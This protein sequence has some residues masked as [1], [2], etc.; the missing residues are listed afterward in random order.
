MMKILKSTMECLGPS[1]ILSKDYTNL[2]LSISQLNSDS[3]VLRKRKK[4]YDII[5]FLKNKIPSFLDIDDGT[6]LT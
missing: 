6:C 4:L 1:C 2:M 3:Y 5:K